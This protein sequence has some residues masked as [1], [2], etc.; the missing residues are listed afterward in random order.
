M[1][2]LITA[3]ISLLVIGGC[4]AGTEPTQTDGEICTLQAGKYEIIS[5]IN[6]TDCPDVF[7]EPDKK[8]KNN[9]TVWN[10]KDTGIECGTDYTDYWERKFRTGPCACV[11]V[12]T[13]VYHVID[14]SNFTVDR[15][16]ELQCVPFYD[17]KDFGCNKKCYAKG[18]VFAGRIE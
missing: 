11:V 3:I 13:D 15:E 6:E 17:P 8:P 16:A 5:V 1:K 7:G 10:M 18:Q 12:Y 4:G 9:G 14:S 2:Q